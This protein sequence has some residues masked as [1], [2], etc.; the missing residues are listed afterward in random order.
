MP[1]FLVDATKC[2]RD[3]ICL[4]E[5]PIRLI[6]LRDDSPA[7]TWIAGADERCVSC[8]HCVAVCPQGAISL[9]TMPVE[10][11]P[12]VDRDLFFSPSQIEQHLRAR[13]SIRN[14]QDRPVPRDVLAR[15]VD[16]ARFAP[17]GTNSQPVEWI[18]AYDGALVRRLAQHTADWIRTKLDEPRTYWLLRRALDC[19]DAGEDIVFTGTA[20]HL[21]FVHGPKASGPTNF[22]IALTYLEVA[23][24]V[25]GLATCWG[26]LLNDAASNWP[27][28]RQELGL[29]EDH[30]CFGAL[31]IGYP[32]HEMRRIPARNPA[33]V[34]WL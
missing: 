25:F 29:P 31:M 17:S 13:R 6:E 9:S 11:C 7:P 32:K 18:V 14:Y 16:I 19:W 34:A 3:G 12:P 10:V 5:C 4:S 28:M 33:R 23:A 24:P 27:P 26:G 2:K 1:T 22:V 15:L 21:V 30:S 8:G 20:P